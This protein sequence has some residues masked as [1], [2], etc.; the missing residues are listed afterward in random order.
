MLSSR[1]PDRIRAGR[2]AASAEHQPKSVGLQFPTL[3]FAMQESKSP[4]FAG[5]EET[6][7]HHPISAISPWPPTL[8]A[9]CKPARDAGSKRY[10]WTPCSHR[11]QLTGASADEMLRRSPLRALRQIRARVCLR[12]GQHRHHHQLR[13]QQLGPDPAAAD[14][15][16]PLESPEFDRPGRPER[17][18]RP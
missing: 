15:L 14:S 3:S 12:G 4:A 13:H 11:P 5:G 2:I 16:R 10:P 17:T 1:H 8:D 6:S 18:A 9:P 7:S